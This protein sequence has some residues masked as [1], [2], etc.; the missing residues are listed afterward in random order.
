MW[1]EAGK[2]T[3]LYIVEEPVVAPVSGPSPVG[4]TLHALFLR[5]VNSRTVK[6]ESKVYQVCWAWV[7][8]KLYVLLDHFVKLY[9]SIVAHGIASNLD[10][11]K[12]SPAEDLCSVPIQYCE[13]TA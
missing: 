4:V 9:W 2:L 7:F 12:S 6:P 5:S 8:V 11:L 10:V 3:H 1:Y 13:P